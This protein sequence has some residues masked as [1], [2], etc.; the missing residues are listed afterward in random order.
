[1]A[2]KVLIEGVIGADTTAS[3]IRAALEGATDIELRINSPGGDAYEGIALH[4]LLAEHRRAGHRIEAVVDGICASAATYIAAAA[5]HVSV[6]ENA[7]WMVHEPHSSAIGTAADFA[8]A[9]KQL[10]ALAEIMVDGYAA[11]TKRTRG[12]IANELKAETFYYGP[13]IIAAGYADAALPALAQHS[14]ERVQ[15]VALARGAVANAMAKLQATPV[16]A[17]APAPPEAVA[18]E[19]S[20]VAERERILAIIRALGLTDARGQTA[21]ELAS[22]PHIT[23]ESAERIL[24]TMATPG[25]T[26]EAQ[27]RLEDEW[28]KRGGP[29]IRGHHSAGLGEGGKPDWQRLLERI[30]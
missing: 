26:P 25:R 5:H 4:N 1:M 11:R 9:S 20:A 19:P 15:A 22:D 21:M 30:A 28:V 8:S 7:V 6:P 10:A 29:E 23:A 16:S 13:E 17:R 27:A 3:G 2:K 12:E 14:G 24:A 18:P